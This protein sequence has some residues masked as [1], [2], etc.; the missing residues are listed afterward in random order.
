MTLFYVHV[1]HTID[2]KLTTHLPRS[3]TTNSRTLAKRQ[4]SPAFLTAHIVRDPGSGQG[5]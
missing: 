3:A 5:L 2:H 1:Y 4:Q